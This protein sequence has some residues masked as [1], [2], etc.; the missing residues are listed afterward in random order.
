MVKNQLEKL[1]NQI[2]FS[3]CPK[4]LF[5]QVILTTVSISFTISCVFKVK[6]FIAVEQLLT[7]MIFIFVT[8]SSVRQSQL[9]KIKCAPDD[10]KWKILVSF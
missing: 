6:S 10:L 2:S 1:L 7:F 5:T 3:L 9:L 4:K 8:S